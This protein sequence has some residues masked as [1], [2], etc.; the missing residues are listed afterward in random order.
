MGF[1]HHKGYA[2]LEFEVPEGA[3]LAQEGMNG[4]IM[5]G[6]NI[7]VERGR[8]QLQLGR[9]QTMPQAQPII[10]MIMTEARKFHRIYVAS[11]H[12]D[13][14]ESDLRDVF[15]SFGNILRCQLAKS[16]GGRHR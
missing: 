12:E 7:K 6:R 2:F 4:I 16:P 8:V 13:L 1:Q 15:S 9:P 3:V 10:D 11:V 5:G 14:T